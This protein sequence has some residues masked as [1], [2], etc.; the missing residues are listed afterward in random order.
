MD[1]FPET[2]EVK[3]FPKQW[4]VNILASVIGDKFRFWVRER[5]EAR[6]EKIATEKDINIDID[7]VIFDIFN[8][9]TNHTNNKGIGAN[10]LKAGAKR[11]V[12]LT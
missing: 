10:L 6:N 1:F 8:K 11:W 12:E 7:P 4:I 3:K 5:I 2:K 9:S